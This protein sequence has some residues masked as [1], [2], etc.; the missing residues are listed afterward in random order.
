MWDVTVDSPAVGRD[1]T[2]RMLLPSRFETA[3]SQRWPVLYLLHGCCDSYEA[4]T[5]STD[6]EKR[7]RN[8]DLLVVMPDGGAAGFYSNWRSGP[9]WET[10]H[11]TELGSLLTREVPGQRSSELSPAFPWAGSV[12]SRYAARNPGM[13]K[14][15]A[16]LQR[17]RAH[18][19]VG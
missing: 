11:L 15:A 12:R 1:V 4:W 7:T 18:S 16:F 13:F 2:V 8:L 3:K 5:R 17:H 9:A 14:V 10:F 19:A 6:I